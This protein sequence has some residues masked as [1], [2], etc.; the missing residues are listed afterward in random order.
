MHEVTRDL[1]DGASQITGRFDLTCRLLSTLIEEH[2]GPGHSDDLTGDA[3]LIAL[4]VMVRYMNEFLSDK[5]TRYANDWRA[6]HFVEDPPDFDL[7]P[8]LHW[9]KWVIAYPTDTRTRFFPHYPGLMHALIGGMSRFVLR[10]EQADREKAR[11][12]YETQTRW[13][14]HPIAKGRPFKNNDQPRG[15]PNVPPKFAWQ[16]PEE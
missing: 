13:Q 7:A 9:A 5:P 15:M 16:P 8:F 4:A 14:R 12:F 1:K 10:L 11:W 3:Y 6:S 2:H